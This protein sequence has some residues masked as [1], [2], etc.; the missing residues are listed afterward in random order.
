MSPALE[1]MALL[2]RQKQAADR[3]HHYWFL[4]RLRIMQGYFGA[5]KFYQHQAARWHERAC[6]LRE[7]IILPVV[8]V[9]NKPNVPFVWE[10]ANRDQHRVMPYTGPTATVDLSIFGSKSNPDPETLA[11]L[12]A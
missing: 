6:E 2:H 4:A 1:R 12:L 9:I 11:R 3:S 5:A 7:D 8:T 10:K